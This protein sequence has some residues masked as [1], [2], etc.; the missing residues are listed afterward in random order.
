MNAAI[1]YGKVSFL[2]MKWLKV[3]LSNYGSYTLNVYIK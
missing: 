2:V 3:S 1:N